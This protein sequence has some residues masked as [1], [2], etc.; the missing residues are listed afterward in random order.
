MA[1]G[2]ALNEVCVQDPK[3]NGI[4]SVNVGGGFGRGMY[5]RLE[6]NEK[7]RCGHRLD[8]F[9]MELD[10]ITEPEVVSHTVL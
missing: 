1:G 6:A 9:P 10:A 8:A 7:G 2:P 4:A 5:D 3:S